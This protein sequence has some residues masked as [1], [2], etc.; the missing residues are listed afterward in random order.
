MSDARISE[1]AEML[2]A[3]AME[4]GDYLITPP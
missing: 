1:V 3:R 2:L 4:Y